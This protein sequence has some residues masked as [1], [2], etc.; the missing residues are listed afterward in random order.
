MK[1]IIKLYEMLEIFIVR[2]KM[3]MLLS[4]RVS[5]VNWILFKLLTINSGVYFYLLIE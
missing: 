5:S 4:V 2:S 3:L 1:Q